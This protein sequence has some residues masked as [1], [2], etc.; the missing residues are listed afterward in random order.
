MSL[1]WDFSTVA[2]HLGT[3]LA[4]AEEE[5]RIEQ[6]VYGL[7]AR[8]ERELQSLLAER[9]ARRYG[10]A[11]E[12]HY[13]ST[14][15]RKLTHRP[16][17][18]LVLT[19]LGQPL[20][21]DVLPE[22]TLFDLPTPGAEAVRYCKPADALWLEVKIA[23]QFREGGVRH[24]G[25]GAQWRQKVVA[26]LRKMEADEQIREAGLVLIVF[27]ESREILDKDLELF[28]DVL[29]LKEVLAGFRQVRSIPILER[30]GHRLCTVA[31]WPTIQR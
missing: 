2:D 17:C 31:V 8:D 6:A 9:L 19:P 12:V 24:G 27:N 23:Y 22:Q 1:K 20:E 30:I 7:D 29:A 25:Y 18:D 11:R 16:R 28:E 21:P 4:E 3:V 14:R 15:G 10:V 5:L 13:P 26:D